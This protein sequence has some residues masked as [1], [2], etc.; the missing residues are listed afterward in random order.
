MGRIESRSSYAKSHFLVRRG[1][2]FR[3]LAIFRK[4]ARAIPDRENA[5]PTL[6]A[7][8]EIEGPSR[9]FIFPDEG[10]N[11]LAEREGRFHLSAIFRS[12]VRARSAQECRKFSQ[13]LRD[14]GRFLAEEPWNR[15]IFPEARK[16]FPDRS[17]GGFSIRS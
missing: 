11:S 5:P 9:P 6:S 16:L 7:T 12:R 4:Q 2:L 14:C 15:Q 17:R 10:N 3:P 1:P 8:A 13:P